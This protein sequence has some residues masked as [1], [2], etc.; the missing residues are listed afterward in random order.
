MSDE[1]PSPVSTSPSPEDSAVPAAEASWVPS[2][3]WTYAALA[4][5]AALS[6]AFG[7]KTVEDAFDVRRLFR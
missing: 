1:R 7:W 3:F 5:V 4:A 6:I 2:A